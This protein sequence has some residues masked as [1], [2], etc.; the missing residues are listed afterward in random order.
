[1]QKKYKIACTGCSFTEGQQLAKDNNNGVE[2]ADYY[3]TWPHVLKNWLDKKHNIQSTIYNAGRAGSSILH[4][5]LSANFL[6]KEFDP[7]IF[8]IQITTYERSMMFLD[9]I[10][11]EENDLYRFGYD[12]DDKDYFK[13]WDNSKSWIHLSPGLGWSASEHNNNKDFYWLL[14]KIY[15]QDIDKKVTPPISFEQFKNYIALWHEQSDANEAYRHFYY[16]HV[17]SLVDFLKAK[18]KIVIPFYWLKYRPKFRSHLFGERQFP[19]MES[20]MG[21]NF[22]NEYS[23][24][25][26]YHLDQKGHVKMMNEFLGPQ[27][28]ETIQ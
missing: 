9:P 15:K 4:N 26:G 21:K 25:K 18:G 8:I 23:I 19:C 5:H 27:V 12:E 22:L 6:L 17:Y 13:V 14:E 20:T 16:T 11:Q 2:I 28:L 3:K 24:D 7:D 10:N 1:M